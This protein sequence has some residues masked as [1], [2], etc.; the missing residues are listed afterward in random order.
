MK[1]TYIIV[2]N[3]GHWGRGKTLHLAAINCHKAGARKTTLGN[4][5]LVI[6]DDGAIF[7][8]FYINRDSSSQLIAIADNIKLGAILASQDTK[9]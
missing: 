3:C 2:T 5:R 7:D 6:G 9:D 8:G 1:K 4:V